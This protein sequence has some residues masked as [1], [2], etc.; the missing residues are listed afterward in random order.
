MSPALLLFLGVALLNQISSLNAAETGTNSQGNFAG[1]HSRHCP[2]PAGGYGANQ[3]AA[4]QWPGRIRP[5][6]GTAQDLRRRLPSPAPTLK[7]RRNRHLPESCWFIRTAPSPAGASPKS[8]KL[9]ISLR[10]K[11]L[12]PRFDLIDQKPKTDP[13]QRR[14]QLQRQMDDLTARLK[15]AQKDEA[16]PATVRQLAADYAFL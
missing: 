6:A 7:N 5:T 14:A 12:S 11:M 1:I 3:R 15:Q 13:A 9:R 4:S 2:P 10:I 8:I 16:S